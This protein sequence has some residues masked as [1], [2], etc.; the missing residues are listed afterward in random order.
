MPSSSGTTSRLSLVFLLF[1][2]FPFL[3]VSWL[4]AVLVRR[5]GL[6]GKT[7]TKLVCSADGVASA[8]LI[9]NAAATD[10]PL[11][12]IGTHECG[13]WTVQY[14]GS[15]VSGMGQFLSSH[16]FNFRVEGSSQMFGCPN[17]Q[18]IWIDTDESWVWWVCPRELPMRIHG[19]S[20]T[21]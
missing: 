11:P 15:W 5:N 16:Q 9:R 18:K 21:P 7:N 2:L 17:M 1:F 4:K 20:T 3:I 6:P 13:W 8:V 10:K 14:L 19:N 12:A